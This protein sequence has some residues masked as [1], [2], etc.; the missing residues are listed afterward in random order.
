MQNNKTG[1]PCTPAVWNEEH[2][3]SHALEFIETPLFES[4]RK[5]LI[6][7]EEFRILQSNIIKKPDLGDLI[8]GTGGLRKVRLAG[9]NTG[10]SGGYRA[11]YLFILP[12]LIFLMLLY[13]KGKK[14]SL[15][16]NEKNALKEISKSIKRE[17]KNE[18]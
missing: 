11:I 17:C 16:Q 15:T 14:D 5:E 7:D 10:K 9:S 3:I 13:K 2:I 8:T 6:N 12:D 18:R 4:Q 1:V